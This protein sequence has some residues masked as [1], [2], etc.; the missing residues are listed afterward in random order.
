MAALMMACIGLGWHGP[1]IATTVTRGIVFDIRCWSA[2]SRG[3]CLRLQHQESEAQSLKA[4]DDE[5]LHL[6]QGRH[7]GRKP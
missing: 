1:P 6:G 5:L 3:E 4:I 7:T 2:K